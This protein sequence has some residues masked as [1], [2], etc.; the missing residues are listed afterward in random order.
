MPA[1]ICA[2]MAL[3]LPG[4][5]SPLPAQDSL[6]QLPAAINPSITY[7]SARTDAPMP[8]AVAT[9]KQ[10]VNTIM[11]DIS[12]GNWSSGGNEFNFTRNVFLEI[13]AVR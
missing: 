4:I 5:A 11:G 2:R 6:D 8:R 12:L 1:R 9:L 3:L 13:T 7:P 10:R